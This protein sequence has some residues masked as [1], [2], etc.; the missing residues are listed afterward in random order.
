M[1]LT[2]RTAEALDLM[3][4]TF[5]T[6]PVTMNP[7]ISTLQRSTQRATFSPTPTRTGRRQM[8][9]QFS[10]EAAGSG[11]LDGTV[12]PAYGK[13]LR[14]CGFAE[15]QFVAAGLATSR[16]GP[17]NERGG[18]VTA[19]DGTD[20]FAG[21]YARLVTLT[22]TGAAEVTVSAA[23]T[24]N[25]GAAYSETGVAV[26][27]ATAI[28]GPEGSKM[29]L[30]F[31]DALVAGDVYL[32][33]YV[34]MGH[35]Y[36]PISDPS[37]T[38]S[39]FLYMY[40]GNKRHL[41]TGARGTV[42]MSATAGE[43]A[44]LNFSFTGDYNAPEAVT[45]PALG[46]YDYGPY[47]LPPMVE[48]AGLQSQGR[49]IACPTTYG[50]DLSGNVTARLCANARGGND[51]AMI[52][53][54]TPTMNFNMD[55][56]PLDVMDPWS[57]FVDA[58]QLA[59]NGNVGTEQGNTLSFLANGQVSNTQYADME[60]LRKNDVTLGLAGVEGNDELMIFVS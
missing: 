9:Y 10:M 55:S 24:P 36:T 3:T 40:A 46:T 15:T 60:S 4:D 45:F 30:T 20:A 29:T 2:F 27:T 34:P 51:G 39:M 38:E 12:A 8:G 28:T 37:T 53:G 31:S 19:A 13:F 42:S 52:T 50:F 44:Q 1:E 22:V 33:W 47:P 21:T 43:Y 14:A 56:V 32:F 25:G 58:T 54:R 57:E 16:S 17:S 48:Q 18:V 23:E 35:L 59:L 6:G 49:I 41:L 26:T 7:N 5:D 11:V